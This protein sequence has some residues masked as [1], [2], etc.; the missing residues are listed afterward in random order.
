VE[1]GGVTGWRGDGGNIFLQNIGDAPIDTVLRAVVLL[2]FV[3][4]EQY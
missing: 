1:A 3:E 2:V 4:A